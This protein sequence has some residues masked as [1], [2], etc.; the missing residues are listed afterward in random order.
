M[1]AEKMLN[2]HLLALMT[3]LA[4]SVVSLA[5]CS[6]I[7]GK[8]GPEPD[9]AIVTA[10]APYRPVDTPGRQRREAQNDAELL[11]RRQL[12]NEIGRMRIT[13][14]ETVNDLIACDTRLR[15]RVMEMVRTAEVHDWFVD[16]QR[17]EVHVTVRLDRN[18]VRELLTPQNDESPQR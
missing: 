13:A 10:C 11:A 7:V 4:I 16:E 8:R 14:K 5:G 6:G 3:I 18:K 9:W 2:C 17:G 15:A 12:L 1:R